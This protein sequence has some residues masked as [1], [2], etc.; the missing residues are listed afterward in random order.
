MLKGQRGPRIP[1]RPG[2]SPPNGFPTCPRDTSREQA[3]ALLNETNPLSIKGILTVA[4]T[5]AIYVKTSESSQSASA[6]VL[7]ISTS[8][9]CHGG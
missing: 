7:A 6:P 2:T 5:L 3:G 9:A 1:P 4:I 8:R